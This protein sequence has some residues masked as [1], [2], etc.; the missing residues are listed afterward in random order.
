MD[1]QLVR[2]KGDMT[3]PRDLNSFDPESMAR[4]LP[5][6]LQSVDDLLGRQARR[7]PVP[8]GLAERVY[9][10]SVGLLT[11]QAQPPQVQVIARVGYHNAWWGRMALAASIA[12]V[13]GVSLRLVH[14]PTLQQ[15]VS[16][17]DSQIQP[18]YRQ[19]VGQT[20]IEMDHLLVTREMTIDDL[21][22]ELALLTADLEM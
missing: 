22:M 8:P 12:L 2:L 5:P 9:L 21:D 11:G 18:V 20:L 10:A 7:L 3:M 16:G 14:T 17:I 19:V 6:H 4:D 1:R 13:C 15:L